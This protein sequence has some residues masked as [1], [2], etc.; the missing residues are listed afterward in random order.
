M[1]EPKVARHQAYISSKKKNRQHIEN[2]TCE[3][4]LYDPFSHQDTA[5]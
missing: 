4:E 5:L 3:A 1:R 2:L